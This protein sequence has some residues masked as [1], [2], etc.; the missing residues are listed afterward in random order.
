MALIFN[1]PMTGPNGSTTITDT[2]GNFSWSVTG[3]AQIQSNA[4]VLDGSGDYVSTTADARL[5]FGS[6]NDFRI[7]FDMKMAA[8]DKSG[9]KII[10]DQLNTGTTNTWTWQVYIYEGVPYFNVYNNYVGNP[11]PVQGTADLADGNWHTVEI[12]RSGGAISMWVDGVQ[13][14]TAS[15]NRD[16]VFQPPF[17]IGSRIGYNAS[18]S[19]DYKGEL[20]NLSISITTPVILTNRIASW[21]R[22]SDIGWNRGR[23]SSFIRRMAFYPVQPV[24]T[25]KV[26]TVKVTRGVPPW[27]GPSGSTTQLPTY[28]LRGRVM[29]RDPDGVLPDA[30]VQYAR[31]VLFFRRLH[32]LVDIQ[33]SDVD[34]YVQ[35]DN[36]MPGSQAYYAI[37]FDP[38]GAPL[39]NAVI[40]DRLSPEPGP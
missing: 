23:R 25:K 17:G 40:W 30:P 13:V 1:L 16:Y 28:K 9:Y 8:A 39:Q 27:W 21:T 19:Y 2:T 4:L 24:T 5:N 7:A 38:E 35:F 6:V 31:V 36:L 3:N 10:F 32:T 14:S 22:H 34:G 26:Q 15:D 11:T 12:I 37:A 18:S 29:Q 33:L 20:R